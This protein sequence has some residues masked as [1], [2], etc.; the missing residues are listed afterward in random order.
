M[1]KNLYLKCD[2]DLLC[3]YVAAF[4]EMLYIGGEFQDVSNVEVYNRLISYSET[5]WIADV[6][7]DIKC[8]EEVYTIIN[9]TL[10]T[11]AYLL[12]NRILQQK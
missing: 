8:A 11:P 5:R 6:C 1:T 9:R 2:A 3:Q 4:C 12:S 10:E 7:T